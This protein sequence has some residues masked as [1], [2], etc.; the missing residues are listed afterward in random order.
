MVW[1]RYIK[2]QGDDLETANYDV[3]YALR[4]CLDGGEKLR[5]ACVEIYTVMRLYVE[6]VSLALKVNDSKSCVY[7]ILSE[8]ESKQVFN[9][10]HI[11]TFL[12]GW[13]W[14]C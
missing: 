2:E 8:M 10:I 5:R 4:L 13:C 9:K 6:A 11:I 1:Y 3:K 12:T 7:F 14:P